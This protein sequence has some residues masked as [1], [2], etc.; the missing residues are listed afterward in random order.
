MK[1]TGLKSTAAVALAAVSLFTASAVQAQAYPSKPIRMIVPFPAG[2]TTDI[3]A[4]I[5]AQRMQ[6]SMGQ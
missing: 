3:V 1:F 5:V 2:G 4:R 6:D